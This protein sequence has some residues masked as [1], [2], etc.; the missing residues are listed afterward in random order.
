MIIFFKPDLD[1]N[2][3]LNPFHL[4]DLSIYFLDVWIFQ[5]SMDMQE[6]HA[7]P[8]ETKT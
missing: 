5:N 7:I 4:S 3:I 8:T 1:S 2:I 6:R